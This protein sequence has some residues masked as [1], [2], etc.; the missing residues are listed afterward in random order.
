[1]LCQPAMVCDSDRTTIVAASVNASQKAT[2]EDLGSASRANKPLSGIIA[3][4][5]AFVTWAF[6]GIGACIDTRGD[7]DAIAVPRDAE[8]IRLQSDLRLHGTPNAP[9]GVISAVATDM[10]GRFYVLDGMSQDLYVFDANGDY[11]GNLGRRGSGPGEFRAAVDV[12]VSPDSIVWVTDAVAGRH[13]LFD[14]DGNFVR[15][16]PRRYRSDSY[17]GDRPFTVDGDH[18]DW[19]LRF[20]NETAFAS[21][22]V[23][24]IFPVIVGVG[25]DADTMP[26][27][28]FWP[29]LVDIGNE[30][31]PAVFFSPAP[32]IAVDGRGS[33]WFSDSREYR[34]LGRSLAGDTTVVLS[35]REE[36]ALVS[37]EDRRELEKLASGRSSMQRYIDVLPERKPII[38]GVFP[39]GAGHV[40]V[41]PETTTVRRGEAI[42]LFRETGEYLGRMMVPDPVNLGITRVVMHATEGFLY[43]GGLDEAGAP[44]LIRLRLAAAQE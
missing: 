27:I 19:M 7:G 32:V 25:T 6:V 31:R 36:A 34:I 11:A 17:V 21:S 20:P 44:V 12:A 8:S 43:I 42:D 23:I 18:V 14:L 15:T 35:L 41:I 37:D 5:L 1:M 22:D 13:V 4:S 10:L 24:E 29:D 26:P 39:D 30:R 3:R 16:V 40:L 9:F 38:V 33:I 2:T 28:R